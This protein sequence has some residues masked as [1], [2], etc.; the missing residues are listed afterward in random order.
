[1]KKQFEIPKDSAEKTEIDS[2]NTVLEILKKTTEKFT[3]LTKERDDIFKKRKWT[4][5]DMNQN[6]K[7]LIK[8]AKLLI[9]LPTLLSSVLKDIDHDVRFKIEFFAEQAQQYLNEKNDL[10]LGT[11]LV[12]KDDKVGDKNSLEKLID[13]LEEKI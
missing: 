13:S 10:G 11:L 5:E 1:M 6:Q 7:I 3:I 2:L 9:N 12:H 8:R 4:E